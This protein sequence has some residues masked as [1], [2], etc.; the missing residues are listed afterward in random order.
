MKSQSAI[1]N[2]PSTDICHNMDKSWNIVLVKEASHK[3]TYIMW[4]H[5]YELSRIG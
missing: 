4:F 5:L 1:E 2:E 3:S